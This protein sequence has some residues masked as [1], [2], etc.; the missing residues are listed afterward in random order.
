MLRLRT[1]LAA[2]MLATGIAQAATSTD[3]PLA[4]A[5][6][7][8]SID[9]VATAR[10]GALDL[11]AIA[12][13][14]ALREASGQPMRFAIAHDS[15]LAAASGGTWEQQGERSVWRY[16]VQARDAASLNF[17]FTRFAL[18]PSAQLF[19][20]ATDNPA[21]LAGPYSAATHNALGQLWTPIIA[22]DDVTIELDVATR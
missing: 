5:N 19:I 22:S 11:V 2:S 4:F 6:P 18:P 8:Q 3:T 13:Q 15:A 20:Y 16:R 7:L 1:L 14:D 12:E 17:G 9:T 21:D 10:F